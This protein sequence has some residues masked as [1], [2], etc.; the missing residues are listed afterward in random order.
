MDRE[1]LNEDRNICS[2][3][4]SKMRR[5]EETS[6]KLL[7][8]VG[9]GQKGSKMVAKQRSGSWLCVTDPVCGE[10]PSGLVSERRFAKKGEARASK[11]LLVHT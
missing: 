9:F 5:R 2:V 11:V 1:V 10:T 4:V 6:R 7:S 3:L 8:V